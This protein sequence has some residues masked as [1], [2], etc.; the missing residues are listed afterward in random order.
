M[1]IDELK[2]FVSLSLASSFFGCKGT[3]HTQAATF[4]PATTSSFSHPPPFPL[5]VSFSFCKAAM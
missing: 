3:V 1:V 5:K 2:V 4:I